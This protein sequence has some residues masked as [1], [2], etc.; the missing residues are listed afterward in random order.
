M[1]NVVI[2]ISLV[3]IDIISTA[4]QCQYYA[5]KFAKSSPLT[6]FSVG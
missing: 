1:K 3:V 2:E 5:I 4:L 6:I